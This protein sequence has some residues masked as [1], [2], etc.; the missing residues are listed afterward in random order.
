M[1]FEKACNHAVFACFRAFFYA[2]TL[3]KI[4]RKSTDFLK[5][6]DSPIQP[7]IYSGEL[8]K[9]FRCKNIC[10]CLAC[11][12]SANST[13]NKTRAIYNLIRVIYNQN[14]VF[15]NLCF[16]TVAVYL[17][18]TYGTE[19]VP[20]QNKRKSRRIYRTVFYNVKI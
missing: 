5:S 7:G 13:N 11:I 14:H 6:T 18:S 10:V 15:Y 19:I 9:L 20:L 2:Q 12:C 1:I 17:Y 4:N 16:G 8:V 3:R